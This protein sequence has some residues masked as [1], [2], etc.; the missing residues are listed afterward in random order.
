[1]IFRPSVCPSHLFTCI[2]KK[3]YKPK[4]THH[5]HL[6]G[7]VVAVVVVIRPF[8]LENQPTKI[9]GEIHQVQIGN[10]GKKASSCVVVLLLEAV[11]THT[12]TI[13]LYTINPIP[14]Q[15]FLFKKYTWETIIIMDILVD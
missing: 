12:Y 1:M 7:R 3:G 14:K 6:F 2:Y 9:F 4:T 15:G 13:I 5:T 10:C 11:L 8:L